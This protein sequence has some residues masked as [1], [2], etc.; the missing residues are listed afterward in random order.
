MGNLNS[1][2]S[3]SAAEIEKLSFDDLSIPGIVF[4][5]NL[6]EKHF[7]FLNDKGREFIGLKNKDG[8]NLIQLS[9]IIHEAD[10]EKII[11]KV[12]E[13]QKGEIL[14][15][16]CSF[17][18]LHYSKQWMP[19][20]SK[21]GIFI[22]DNNVQILKGIIHSLSDEIINSNILLNCIESKSKP[23]E[24]VNLVDL[25]TNR[26]EE[27]FRFICDGLKNNQIAEALNI[28]IHTVKTHRKRILKKLDVNTSMELHK[29][30]VS[31]L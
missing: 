18:M 16:S 25:L 10:I 4:T 17:R 27:I 31:N 9:D 5:Y 7:C 8:V 12:R 3:N 13:M 6:D 23:K 11:I 21:I 14:Y 24:F 22:I 15:H 30:S 20:F 2:S 26:E 19:M 28:S 29:F 1:N